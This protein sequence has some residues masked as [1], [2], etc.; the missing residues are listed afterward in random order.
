M[1]PI[2]PGLIAALALLAG[3]TAV[4][5][6]SPYSYPWCEYYLGGRGGGGTSCYFT[7]YGQCMASAQGN[8]AYCA[9]NPQYRPQ[10]TAYRRGRRP[11]DGPPADGGAR[12]DYRHW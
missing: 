12:W 10:A 5:A 7:S 11:V 9:R 2:G 1:R 3:G 8:G 4:Q 6:Q